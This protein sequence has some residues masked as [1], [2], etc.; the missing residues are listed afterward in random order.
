MKLMHLSD[1][2]KQ[3]LIAYG[4]TIGIKLESKLT[5]AVMIERLNASPV[6]AA[7]K[8]KQDALE[9]LEQLVIEAAEN[10]KKS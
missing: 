5:K 9:M 10:F 1:M 7:E 4:I 6:S 2:T 8:R 3:E